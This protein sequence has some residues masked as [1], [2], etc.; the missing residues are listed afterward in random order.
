MKSIDLE[1]FEVSSRTIAVIGNKDEAGNN[2][3]RIIESDGEFIIQAKP[4]I[5]ID[6]SCK[7]FGSSLKGRQDGTKEVAGITHKAP[8]TVD[9]SSGIYMFPTKSPHK[10]NCAWIAHSYILRYESE[11]FD[12]T[13]V[14]F[15]NGMKIRLDISSGSFENQ[16][17]RTA[18]YR[19]LLSER[20]NL[21]F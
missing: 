15:S 20:I 4:L 14:T 1:D 10:D 11:S 6:K 2:Y 13:I 8:I 9:P 3:S 16:V 12:Q 5:I 17:N 18:Q 19:Y 21:K 7:Y